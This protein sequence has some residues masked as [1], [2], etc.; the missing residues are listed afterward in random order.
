MPKIVNHDCQKE[1]I[2]KAAWRVIQ[3]DG[4]ENATVRKIA[5]EANV[6]LGALRHYFSSQVELL[7]FAMLMVSNH[8]EKR[9]ANMD[10]LLDTISLSAAKEVLLNFIPV[11]E[12]RKLEM[13]VWLSMSIKALNEPSLEK[14][15]NDT[16]ESMH[17][18]IFTMLQQLSEAHIIKEAIDLE[19]EAQ[20]LQ[21]LV[22]GLSFH[23]MI[24]PDKITVDE[25]DSI[26]ANHLDGLC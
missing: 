11:D 2:A 6:S 1:I 12:E 15:R 14:I 21:V 24:C 4:I 7:E 26:L 8:I 22:D 9:L 25:V 3:K 5:Q 13:K 17:K 10:A 20:Q 23:L 16:Y 18:T 19:F